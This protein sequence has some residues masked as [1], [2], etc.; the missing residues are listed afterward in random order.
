VLGV[1]FI[2]KVEFVQA[3]PPP[4]PR[5]TV[6]SLGGRTSLHSVIH[7]RRLRR[8]ASLTPP[9]TPHRLL[10]K[11]PPLRKHSSADFLHTHTL[12]CGLLVVAKVKQI[13]RST[14]ANDSSN[15]AA[16]VEINVLLVFDEMQ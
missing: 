15:F 12:R 1:E 13:A 5:E 10:T 9:S 16:I 3:P 6:A 2:E 4:P 8:H 14:R 11:L 7:K